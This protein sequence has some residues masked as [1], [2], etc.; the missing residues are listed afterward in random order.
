MSAQGLSRADEGG[1]Q[2]MSLI[3]RVA[4]SQSWLNGP[5]YTETFYRPAKS[6]VFGI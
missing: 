2:W 1:T 6:L 4:R 3:L 5:Q